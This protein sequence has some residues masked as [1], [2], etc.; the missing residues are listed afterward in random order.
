VNRLVGK[1]NLYRAADS[2]FSLLSAI[3]LQSPAP[4]KDEVG[5]MP[6][7]CTAKGSMPAIVAEPVGEERQQRLRDNPDHR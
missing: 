4:A 6:Q 5:F 1:T 2:S 7:V 3:C